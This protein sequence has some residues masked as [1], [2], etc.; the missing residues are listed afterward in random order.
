MVP[1]IWIVADLTGEGF[2]TSAFEL[3]SKARELASSVTV[4]VF[5][6]DPDLAQ[7]E[8][9]S[10]GADYIVNLGSTQGRLAG[11]MVAAALAAEFEGSSAPS[12]VLVTQSYVG[13]DIAAA[14]SV[15][16]GAPVLTNATDLEVVNDRI[17][18]VNLIFGGE[19]V[20]RSAPTAAS[21]VVVVV[22]PKSFADVS[23][24]PSTPS[25]TTRSLNTDAPEARATIVERH[26]EDRTGPKLD[27]A[28]VVVAGGRGLG[29]P[30]HYALIEELAQV[31]H[32]APGASRAIVDAG[33][34]PYS[35]QVGQTGKTVKPN[36]YVAVGISGATQHMVGMK[37]SKH[38]I[39][40][41]KDKDAP[42]L[43]IADLG[44]IGDAQKV[45]PRLIEAIRAKKG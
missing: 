21:T 44:V 33:W 39:A 24:T 35:Y 7:R 15:C 18:V 25:L 29:A 27:E 22:R 38:I 19:K 11:P 4:V 36:L 10:R 40:I 13:R 30:E 12:A 45:L 1:S 37:G 3:A 9:A 42:I 2:A 43:Q 31:L 32:G 34:V 14:L 8:F 20:V 16:L 41:N 26:V 28:A 23:T 6:V 5:D 17:E